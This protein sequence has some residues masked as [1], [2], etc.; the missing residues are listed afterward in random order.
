[1]GKWQEGPDY[2]NGYTDDEYRGISV[3]RLNLNWSRSPDPFSYLYN[4]PVIAGFLE[5]YLDEIRPELV[6]VT[7]CE[8]LSASVLEVIHQAGL[9]L[10]LS[11]TDFWFLCPQ[12]NLLRSD[13]SNCDGVTSAWDCL[14][15]R[16]D[17]SKAYR[18]PERL[19]PEKALEVL[20]TTISRYPAITR[21]RGLRGM[22]GNM[23]A[24]KT[25]LRQALEWPDQ[26]ITASPFVRDVFVTNGIDQPIRVQPYGHDLSWRD[27]D[28]KKRRSDRVRFG[29]VGQLIQSKGVHL[30]PQAMKSLPEDVR[31]RMSL[32][33]Y[34]NLDHDPDYSQRLQAI[35]AGID[36]LRFA[37]VYPHA[38]SARIFADIDVLLVP[39]LWYD[40]PLVIYEAF[41]THT[42][43]IATRLGGMAEAIEDGVSGLLFDRGDAEN[44]AR[45]MNQIITERG[46]LDRLRERVPTVKT[47]SEELNELGS[48]Y[49]E[50]MMNV[51]EKQISSLEFDT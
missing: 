40:F 26:L 44:L 14:Q 15:C 33:I 36:N 45:Q 21:Q 20:L 34:G 41:A 19:L 50:L 2:W 17:G 11:L 3:R 48:I 22:A 31:S 46:L 5:G 8:T 37:G 13:G 4:N 25:Y 43:V 7:S 49:G 47:V 23:A 9:P 38:E 29:Y 18:L 24:R 35:S 28:Q 32:S 51:T 12:I 6:H 10:V 27:S 39:S 30:L 16:M 42:P 1:M